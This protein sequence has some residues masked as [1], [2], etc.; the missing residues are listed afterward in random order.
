MKVSAHPLQTFI[1]AMCDHHA[2]VC[3]QDARHARNLHQPLPDC[4]MQPFSPLLPLL[5]NHL[6]FF[7]HF[8]PVPKTPAPSD[9]FLCPD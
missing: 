3:D 5:Y 7:N 8:F 9:G 6:L 1:P 2:A 4:P